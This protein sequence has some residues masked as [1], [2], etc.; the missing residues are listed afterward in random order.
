[1]PYALR[2][3]G[4]IRPTDQ[5]TV[6]KHDFLLS[7]VKSSA[8]KKLPPYYFIYFMLVDLLGFRNLGRF[9][10]ISWSIPID[11]N[12]KAFLIEHRKF[13]VGIFTQDAEQDEEAAEQIASHTQSA[14]RASRRYFDWLASNAAKGNELNVVNKSYALFYRYEFFRDS[15]RSKLEEA[16]QLNEVMVGVDKNATPIAGLLLKAFP[17][18]G[19]DA[20]ATALGMAAIEAFCS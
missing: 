13:G 14:V 15:Y 5:S 19:R 7:A 11:Y 1:M 9:E 20:E 4:P 6:A 17:R 2:A 10:K 12:G 3:L 16:A 18:L 8:S